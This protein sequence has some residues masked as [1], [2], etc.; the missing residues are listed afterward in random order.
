MRCH[1]RLSLSA[2][3]I[4]LS[5]I[6]AARSGLALSSSMTYFSKR[7][8]CVD[9]EE[10]PYSDREGPCGRSGLQA[11]KSSRKAASKVK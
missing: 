7:A 5:C 9:C 11:L 10:A 6:R 3:A 1:W 4:T 8:L 2:M